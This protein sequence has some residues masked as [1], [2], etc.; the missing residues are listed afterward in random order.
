MLPH[1]RLDDGTYRAIAGDK[2]LYMRKDGSACADE[3]DQAGGCEGGGGGGAEWEVSC[4][5]EEWGSFWSSY[6]DLGRDYSA[7]RA[8]CR[9]RNAFVD[10]AMDYGARTAHS[11]AGP[12]G[13]ADHVHRVAAQEHA[14]NR[15]RGGAAGP[16]ASEALWRPS[17]KPC[18]RFPRPSSSPKPARTTCAHAALAIAH[19]T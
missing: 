1:S 17:A 6:F 11:C 4:T 13:D 2:V 14:R 15:Q 8:A 3:A 9:G 19:P 10:E 5:P 16:S 12:L 7:I 18:T